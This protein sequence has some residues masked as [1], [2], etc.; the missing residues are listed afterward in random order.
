MASKKKKVAT[1]TTKKTTKKVAKKAT[2]KVA[3]KTTKK[4]AKKTTKKVAKKTTKKVAKKATKK[5]AKKT[6]KKVAK[7]TTKKVAKKTTK[8]VAKKAAK[9]VA[10]KAAKPLAHEIKALPTS[11]RAMSA[12]MAAFVEPPP[13]R[14]PGH[15]APDKN[16]DRSKTISMRG[17]GAYA[18]P[19]PSHAAAVTM[20]P[21][22]TAARRAAARASFVAGD[23]TE[24][25]AQ[26]ALAS[27]LDKKA[28]NGVILRVTELTSYADFF[29]IVSAP[30]ER[31]VQAIAKNVADDLQAAFGRQPMAVDGREQG[32]WVVVDYGSVVVHCFLEQARAYYDL[33]GFWHEAPKVEFD[34]DRGLA[35][36]AFY[37][38]QNAP[39]GDDGDS[40]PG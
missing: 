7:K 31:Q 11:P 14:A 36:L 34:E 4:A 5:V 12:A 9:N 32:N 15:V 40:Q 26:V 24:D 35:A 18:P 33:D 13:A 27:A 20:V 25:F 1:K 30:S 23:A 21:K 29:V 17:L 39:S 8:K 37:R 16:V 10:N 38:E 6:T 28:D 22:E 3:K 2:K 19:P